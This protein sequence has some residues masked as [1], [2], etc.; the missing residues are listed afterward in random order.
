MAALPDLLSRGNFTREEVNR[1]EESGVLTG[2][3]ELLEGELIDKMGQ[4]PPHAWALHRVYAWLIRVFGVERLR[5]QV[6][7]EVAESDR[8]RND[9]Q[10]D[11]AVLAEARTEYAR[12][13]PRGD[14]LTLLVEVAD[15]SSR[16]DLTVKAALYARAGVPEYWVLDLSRR[17]LVI[18]RGAER[19]ELAEHES[20]SL[21]D[22]KAL[23]SDL[24]P[25]Q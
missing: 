9:P 8:R 2:R 5:N 7:I 17:T 10:P 3:Y 1:L 24:L 13:Q 15:T 23:I 18:H 21:G 20:V 6:P 25:P 22:Q 12:R 4:N 19:T 11:I 14:E 16:F